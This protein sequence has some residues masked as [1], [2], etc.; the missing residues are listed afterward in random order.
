MRMDG[1]HPRMVVASGHLAIS[2]ALRGPSRATVD[3]APRRNV[4]SVLSGTYEAAKSGNRLRR[5]FFGP[6]S[7][8]AGRRYSLAMTH[9]TPD[10]LAA[11]L[12]DLTAIRRDIHRHTETAF[13]EERTSQIV[14]D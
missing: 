12:A 3:R 2:L 13:E 14:A 6:F 4:T 9:F 8:C 11:D 5:F 10:L 7:F 1:L